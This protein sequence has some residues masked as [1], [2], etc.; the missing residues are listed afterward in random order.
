[1]SKV[2]FIT[3]SSRGLGRCL[4]EAVLAD[5]Q[6]LVATARRPEQLSDLVARYGPQVCAVALD[7]TDQV[8]IAAAVEAGLAAFGRL[9]VVVNNAG[10]GRLCAIE[11]TTDDELRAQVETNLWGVV[12][13]TRAALPVLRRQRSGHFIQVSSMGGR[14]AAGPG[15]VGYITAKH[16]VEAFSEILSCEVASLGIKVT[17]VEP[18][19]FRTDWAGPS[20]TVT[21]PWEDYRPSVEPMIQFFRSAAGREPGDPARAA[22]I[23]LQVAAMAG[24]PLRLLLGNDAVDVVRQVETAK[25]AEIDRWE[26]LSRSTDYR[27]VL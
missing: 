16:G 14:A 11:Q 5:G 13:V 1:M 17:L 3:G 22:Q 7:V 24:P 6:R 26:E 2:W 27:T 15:L 25:L 21:E 9:D 23:I 12:N 8:Q 18:G 20:L 4:A 10:Y 19:A